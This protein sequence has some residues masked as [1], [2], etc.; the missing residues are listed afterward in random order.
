MNADLLS[1]NKENLYTFQ[2][3]EDNHSNYQFLHEN[4]D[5]NNIHVG[6]DAFSKMEEQELNNQFSNLSMQ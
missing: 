5:I 4:D 6:N 1:A 3:N 2:D